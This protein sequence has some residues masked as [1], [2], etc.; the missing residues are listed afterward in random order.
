M[1]GYRK[2]R[3]P[4]PWEDSVLTNEKAAWASDSLCL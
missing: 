2:G 1:R 3:M 4:V